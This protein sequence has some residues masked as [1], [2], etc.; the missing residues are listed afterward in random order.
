[1]ISLLFL[2]HVASTATI[3]VSDKCIAPTDA[4]YFIATKTVAI[5][6]TELQL[7]EE[8]VVHEL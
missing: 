3:I 7:Q 4:K 2:L 1:M 6:Q 5:C 8:A